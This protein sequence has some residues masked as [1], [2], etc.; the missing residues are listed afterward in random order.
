MSAVA[1]AAVEIKAVDGGSGT[2]VG[3]DVDISVIRDAATPSSPPAAKKGTRRPCDGSP[4]SCIPTAS[5]HMASS[6][7]SEIELS[8]PSEG[9]KAPAPD[10]RALKQRCS[11]Q[12]R[13][14]LSFVMLIS[15][16]IV[17]PTLALCF[18]R[19]LAPAPMPAAHKLGQRTLYTHVA[20]AQR[21]ASTVA[22]MDSLE[23]PQLTQMLALGRSLRH[24]L[25]AA[26]HGFRRPEAAA[27]PRSST[28]P[29]QPHKR[30]MRW[31]VQTVE[32]TGRVL[33]SEEN[34]YLLLITGG[35]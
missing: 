31:V 19:S 32:R 11:N 5:S 26:A 21:S 25:R 35:F 14:R 17:A 16:C 18:S 7:P 34:L 2:C 15:L 27:N 3:I 29:S 8:D 6:Q 10:S 24:S 20:G 4:T 9:A 23:G 12:H 1:A 13:S 33:C 30:A 28:L 22:P